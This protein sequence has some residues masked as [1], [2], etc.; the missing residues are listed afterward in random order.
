MKEYG[1]VQKLTDDLTG[2]MR[3]DR[4]TVNVIGMT[5]LGLM[6]L[7]RKKTRKPL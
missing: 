2:Y 1:N 5:E 3:G 4:L 6:Q 7:T